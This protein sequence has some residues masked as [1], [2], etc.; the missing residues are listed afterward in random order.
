MLNLKLFFISSQ[1]GEWW[2]EQSLHGL[3]LLCAK[4]YLRGALTCLQLRR[5]IRQVSL[6]KCRCPI[7]T[8]SQ[9]SL[10]YSCHKHQSQTFGFQ[11]FGGVKRRENKKKT[12]Y[13]LL[14][15]VQH[16][17]TN[18]EMS[19]TK[20]Y[21]LELPWSSSISVLSSGK[22]VNPADMCSRQDSASAVLT[23]WK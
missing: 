4:V 8:V 12:C 6:E 20:L 23:A 18:P 22:E 16:L 11:M 7:L 15:V 1:N 5:S 3:T 2:S 10:L 17:I 19:R 13:W 21:C 14:S 9:T